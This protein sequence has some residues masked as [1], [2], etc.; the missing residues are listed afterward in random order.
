MIS[1]EPGE[2]RQAQKLRDMGFT[3]IDKELSLQVRGSLPRKLS[4]NERRRLR[5]QKYRPW[6]TMTS[7]V[8]FA[9]DETGQSWHG[10]PNTDLSPLGYDNRTEDAEAGLSAIRNTDRSYH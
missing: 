1:K 3:P 10:P 5:K 7:E 6:F 4:R 9:T 8:T 2:A